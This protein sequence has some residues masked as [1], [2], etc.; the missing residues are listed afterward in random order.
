M[1]G[2][3][4]WDVGD[5]SRPSLVTPVSFKSTFGPVKEDHHPFGR[6]TIAQSRKRRVLAECD[7]LFL[8]VYEQRILRILA[9]GANIGISRELKYSVCIDDDDDCGLE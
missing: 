2:T 1:K 6:A 3:L 8:C 4:A 9:I 7:T 5:C